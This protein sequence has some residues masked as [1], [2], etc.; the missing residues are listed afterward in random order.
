MQARDE[1]LAGRHHD[2]FPLHVWMIGSGTQF[3]MN[4]NEVISNHCCQVAGTP[5]GSHQPV[6]PNDH[7]NMARSSN[8]SFP[9]AMRVVVAF[10]VKKRLVPAVAALRNAIGKNAQAWDDIVKNRWDP[11]AG[12]H[13]AD[14]GAGMVGRCRDVIR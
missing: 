7:V 12:R 4:V 10:N 14:I 13:T 9:S 2:M 1:T 8:Y 11:Y 6:Q 3:N 5:L